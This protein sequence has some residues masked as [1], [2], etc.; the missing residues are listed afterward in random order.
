MTDGLLAPPEVVPADELPP[1]DRR[2]T[3]AS[4]RTLRRVVR[5]PTAMLALGFIAFVALVALLGPTLA[6]K[7]PNRTSIVNA[8]AAPS[9]EF[10]LGTDD[11]G[12]DMASRLIHATRLSMRT[13]LQAILLAVVLAIPLGLVAGYFRKWPDAI[14]MRI[15]DGIGAF[16]PV[17]LALAIA[18][19]L[20]PGSA[21][22]S[23]AVAVVFLPGMMR[24]ARGQVLAVREEVYIEASRSVGSPHRRII[25]S[26]VL[27]N[28]APAVI[29]QIAVAFGFVLITESGLSYLGLGDPLPAASWGSMLQQGFAAYTQGYSARLVLFP[30][31][32]ITSTVLAFQLLGDG[33]RDALG[34]EAVK[35]RR[36]D[37][38]F[39]LDRA[40]APSPAPTTAV[41]GDVLTV[42]GLAV[43]FATP[44]GWVRVVDDVSFSVGAGRTVGLVGESGSG[45]SVSVL[46]VMGLL[47]KGRGRI[48][49]GSVR[50]H[51][52]ELV[53][54]GPKGRK[55]IQGNDIAMVFQEPMTSL[56]PA[57]TVGNQIMEAVR[58][59]TKASRR[60]ARARAVEVLELV[61]IPDPARRLDDYPH[62]FSGGMRQRV[63]IAMALACEPKVLIADEPTTALD[64]TIQAQILELF[65]KL[66]DELGMAIVFVTHDLGVVADVCHEVAVLYAGQVV[67]RA[68]VDD[69]FQ[70]PRHPYTQGL[71]DSMPQATPV[72]GELAVIAGQV[73]L[74]EAMVRGCRFHPR[75]PH[76]VTACTEAPV[77]LTAFRA[78][79]HDGV[80]RC[81]RAAELEL[82]GARIAAT[83]DA[84]TIEPRTGD[85][86]VTTED[87]AVDFPIRS[88]ILRRVTG[89]V[90]AVDGV[91]LEVR[92]GET[93]GLVGESGSGKSTTGRAM[94]RLVELTR[95]R[96]VVDGREVSALTGRALRDARHDMQMVF[97]DPYSS[98]DPRRT[99]AEAV[100]E[101]LEVHLGLRGARRDDEV[102][103]LLD[104]VGIGGHALQRYPY[105][106]SGGQRQRIAI[107]RALA[108][109]PAFVVCDEPVSSLDVSTQS[110]VINLLA[111]LQ[112]RLGIAF[113][114]I[115]H[116]LSV[117]AH[118][119]HRI[120]VMYLG[121]IVETGPT[122]EVIARPRHPYTQA[123]LSAVPVPDPTIQRERRRIVL[124]GDIPSPSNPP[125]GCHFHTRC[126][127]VMDVCRTVV[128]PVFTDAS[129]TTALCH[130]HTE[131]PVLD[132]RPVTELTP[133]LRDGVPVARRSD[134]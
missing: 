57:F 75:C 22:L 55:A 53:G 102:A 133:E 128:P 95:G 62:Q 110:Q 90:H 17:L 14:L 101:P 54:L 124:S 96:V 42:E 103:R 38:R 88:G 120:A 49:S 132:G 28:V 80:V 36:R 78:A 97:Q 129:G 86:V 81:I 92:P 45:K 34:R 117:V 87:V 25:L 16:P 122:A 131:G 105:E 24:L 40:A 8:D 29:I 108:L 43:E 67:E 115:A 70:R 19:M 60:Q 39:A 15:A 104:L 35:V 44:R 121:S 1:A 13:G 63:M 83:A 94:L 79:H 68:D 113:L 12:R 114:F 85:A 20:G 107:A 65:K 23:L 109:N 134:G 82:A 111:D 50:L 89:H 61:G 98:L 31:L 119:S 126:P 64:V 51:G 26:H 127:Y 32:A 74:P 4:W 2:R 69:L 18:A 130:L 6:P 47:P 37:R 58:A 106:F 91:S 66:Q 100:G 112:R 56:N 71:L 118:I 21:N 10:W 77:A 59:H 7:D 41:A 76:A 5:N 99:I 30:A 11:L 125:A 9:G 84:I 3:S 27:P 93:L 52:R 46:A 73:P 116:D 72:G 123:L 33:L 48:V